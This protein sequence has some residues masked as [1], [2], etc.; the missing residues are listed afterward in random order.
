MQW[1]L[2]TVQF[3]LFPPQNYLAEEILLGTIIIHPSIFPQITPLIKED[4]FFLECHQIIYKNLIT[5]HRKNKLDIIQ[6]LYSLSNTKALNTIGGINKIIE[7]MK[8]SQVFMSS[9]NII[10]YTKELVEIINNDYIKRLIIQYGYN[11]INLGYIKKIPS[12]QLYNQATNQLNTTAEKIPKEN[13][14]NFKTLI[15]DFLL[16]LHKKDSDSALIEQTNNDKYCLVSGFQE[17]DK[18]TNGLPNG[19][20]IVVAGRPSTGKTSLAINI[21]YNIITDIKIGIC[22]FSL[23]MSKMQILQK[24]ISIA[25]TIPTK[26][27]ILNQISSKEWEDIKTICKKLLSSKIYLND[28][29]NMSVDYI[30]YT[31]KLLKKET[32]YVELIIIDYLQLIQTEGIYCE[33]RSQELSYITRKLK[34]LAQNLN[35]PIIIL[36]QL[37]RSIE[38]RVNKQPLLSDLRE[39]GCLN[40]SILISHNYVN[41]LH[42][43]TI[44]SNDKIQQYIQ[45]MQ[46]NHINNQ[47]DILIKKQIQIAYQAIHILLQY[48]F[49]VHINIYDYLEITQNHKLYTKQKWTKQNCMIEKEKILK[50]STFY[51]NRIKNSILENSYIINLSYIKY[52]TVYDI[53][54]DDYSNFI[55]QNIIL[56]N[57]I[58]Q[59]ADLVM[60]LK[61]K[62]KQENLTLKV[63]D[64]FLC[65]N[66][67]GPTGCCQI[68]FS[69]ENTTFANLQSQQ[70]LS[71]FDEEDFIS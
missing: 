9:S 19:D 63:I 7:L 32:H 50:K 35:V 33:N 38:T 69:L 53:K 61:E 39:S 26:Q 56:H 66:R 23:E 36:S 15:G 43:A 41:Q 20:L 70:L 64:I 54:I 17:L 49:R 48:I 60:I 27:I 68:L 62:T 1:S 67:N 12:H 5:I 71:V 65:K 21:A 58:E 59:D 34:L 16:S 52:S 11:I 42:L 40:I 47:Y 29:P 24:L 18:L 46:T 45:I 28:T 6:L 2:H 25:S 4:S 14:H 10:V 30:E 57:S 37:N 13:M 31:T 8:Q 51:S 22:I 3:Y 44:F 55:A